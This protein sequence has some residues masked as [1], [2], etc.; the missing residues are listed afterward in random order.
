[1]SRAMNVRD[2][3][4]GALM[5]AFGAF[6]AYYSR[7]YDMGT[8]ERMGPG[9]FPTLLAYALMVVGGLILVPALYKRGGK[10]PP[11]EFRSFA[12]VMLA[13]GVFA[14]IA[15]YFGIVPGIV[16]LTI[17]SSFADRRISLVNLVVL[18]A[19]LSAIAVVVFDTLLGTA[20]APLRWPF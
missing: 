16:A 11:F 10:G 12:F 9:M 14:V 2:V 15:P 19:A 1:M 7:R 18:P 4:S 20:L 17:V 6:V 5:I 13:I 3:V 8:F